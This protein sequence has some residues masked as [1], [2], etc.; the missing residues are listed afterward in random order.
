MK[1]SKAVGVTGP[2]FYRR[3]TAAQYSTWHRGG[4][5][6]HR[7]GMEWAIKRLD[8]ERDD[9]LYCQR[10]LLANVQPGPVDAYRVNLELLKYMLDEDAGSRA[11]TLGAFHVALF[12]LGY[13]TLPT[14]AGEMVG[15]T[16]ASVRDVARRQTNG[17]G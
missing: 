1:T 8:A 15:C 16:E 5:E 11:I 6:W 14:M 2:E 3:V 10:W 7:G 13:P 9:I 17:G 4:G 12:R